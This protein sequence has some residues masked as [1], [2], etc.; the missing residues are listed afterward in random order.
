MNDVNVTGVSLVVTIFGVLL[1]AHESLM[2]SDFSCMY[3]LPVHMG[4]CVAC[5]MCFVMPITLSIYK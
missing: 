3:A 1:I 2:L 5:Y 4:I